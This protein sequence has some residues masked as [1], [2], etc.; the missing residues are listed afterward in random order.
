[1]S[2][3]FAKCV[4][5]CAAAALASIAPAQGQGGS[6]SLQSGGKFEEAIRAQLPAPPAGFTWQIFKN[7][8]L[9]RPDGWNVKTIDQQT[10]PVPVSVYAASPEQFSEGKQFEL[11]ITLQIISGPQALRSTTATKAALLYLKPFL[12]A[13]KQEDFLILE[14]NVRGSFERTIVRFRDAPPGAKPIVVHKFI[15]A[16][17]TADSV[18]VFTFESP[19]DTWQENWERFGTPILSKVS[20]L[21]NLPSR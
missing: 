14:R 19:A 21:P 13:H 12:D 8:V 7:A 1:M 15:L 16:N 2:S 10:S 20:V 17:D 18:H 9:L 4:V 3:I 6:D 11:G 5:A